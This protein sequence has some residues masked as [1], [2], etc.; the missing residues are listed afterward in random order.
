MIGAISSALLAII[1]NSLIQY[2][3]KASL[4]R[5]LVSF[6]ITLLAL[7]ASYAPMVI[8]QFS[9][10]KDKI[11]IAGKLGAEPDILINLYK[12]LIEENSDLR[13]E[14]KS[15][16]GK[17]SFLYEALKSGDIDI[18]LEFTG[19]I[20][21]SLL[22]EKPKLSNDPET[23]YQEA[24]KGIAKQ[25]QLS[26]LQPFAYQNT[27]AVAV[28]EKIAKDY[29]ISSISDLKAHEGQ[30]KAGFTLEFKDRE[31]GFKGMQR[32]YDLKDLS[33]ATM[34]PALRYQAIQS[35]DIQVTDAYSTD[36]EITKYHLQVLKDDKHLFPPYQGAPLMK[37][38]LLKKHPQLKEILNRLAGKI[39]EKEMQDM[40]YRISVKGEDAQKVA[41][42][43]LVKEKLLSN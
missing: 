27:Y 1:F 3:E 19:T 36:A 31:D 12:E 8:G 23:V 4:R 7:L 16:F 26:L 24:K 39:T 18:Y 21:S 41:H 20:T 34:E 17:T 6:I 11:V 13:V 35:G 5:I 38:S 43:Y 42:D 37:N 25:D 14:L 22:R 9:K 40:N 32:V 15:N 28:P 10:N 30:L 2:L 29:G 33:V